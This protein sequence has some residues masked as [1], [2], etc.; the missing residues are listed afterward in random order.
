[1][2]SAPRVLYTS[3]E[4]RSAIVN[5]FRDRLS[6]RIAISAF[7]GD[8]ADA[9]LPYPD[10]LHLICSPTPGATNPN[11]LRLLMSRGVRVEFV[12]SL[13]M[14]IYWANKRGAVVTSANLSTNAM[15]VGGLKE[16]GVLLGPEELDIKRLLKHL[17]RRPAEPELRLL[18]RKHKDFYK[19]VGWT[20]P[21]SPRPSY[22]EWFNSPA[23][24]RWK[25][26]LYST[27]SYDLSE[28]ATHSI[29]QEFNRKP[30]DWIWSQLP[31]VHENDWILCGFTSRGRLQK[32]TWLFADQVFAVPKSDHNYDSE[33]PHEVVQIHGAK[34]YPPPPFSANEELCKSLRQILADTIRK[35]TA[36]PFELRPKELRS[37]YE[38]LQ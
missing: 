26:F 37:I 14:K 13:H 5:L 17:K 35:E 3:T 4:V 31:T 6:E 24:A 29:R 34:H 11:T 20:G 8:G 12:N 30:H 28:M 38:A 33:F 19:R 25:V 15:G 18:D 2:A 27:A 21:K 22:V 10:G 16:A 23:R 9:Y 32:L 1:M 7:V 36:T